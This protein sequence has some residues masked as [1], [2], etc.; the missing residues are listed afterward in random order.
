MFLEPDR[1]KFFY[2]ATIFDDEH[3][4]KDTIHTEVYDIGA[5]LAQD[6]YPHQYSCIFAS[7]TLSTGVKK[8]SNVIGSRRSA[9]SASE[10]EAKS[11]TDNI[12]YND[13]DDDFD[14]NQDLTCAS[15]DE[16]MQD[17]NY[18]NDFD[19]P[20]NFY[21]KYD[22]FKNKEYSEEQVFNR[23][24]YLTR[25]LGSLSFAQDCYE[26]DFSFFMERSGLGRVSNK[27]VYAINIESDFDYNNNMCVI[28]P[29]DVPYYKE[30][31]YLSK[32]KNCLLKVHKAM[33]GG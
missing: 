11:A 33:D 1:P 8:A 17:V 21:D 32:L 10:I 12:F 31:N 22:F 9:S 16:Y 4:N 18:Y 15:P 7:A 6:F 30:K 13:I 26:Q 19:L 2:F 27:K 20:S 28:I 24:S 5:V 14:V 29:N 23:S 25:K 3:S